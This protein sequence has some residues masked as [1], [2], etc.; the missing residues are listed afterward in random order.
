[1][2]IAQTHAL[3]SSQPNAGNK[4]ILLDILFSDITFK[5][6]VNVY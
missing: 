3:A 2:A 5:T 1:M 6:W 4:V